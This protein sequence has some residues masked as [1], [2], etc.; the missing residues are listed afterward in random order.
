[1]PTWAREASRPSRSMPRP[2]AQG[3]PQPDHL[4]SLLE[5]HLR[6]PSR[7]PAQRFEKH[8][9]PPIHIIYSG[10]WV[11]AKENAFSREGDDV[12]GQCMN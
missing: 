9:E 10:A 4:G 8:F 2:V 7:S 11:L 1:M 12:P 5:H 6:Q 3:L